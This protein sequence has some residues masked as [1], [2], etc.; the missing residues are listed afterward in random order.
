[1]WIKK[2]SASAANQS[3]K[4][5]SYN[6]KL[7]V[8]QS[9]PSHASTWSTPLP[10]VCTNYSVLHNKMINATDCPLWSDFFA[11][12]LGPAHPDPSI[13]CCSHSSFSSFPLT[14][15]V[16]TVHTI[17]SPSKPSPSP[18]VGA[19]VAKVLKRLFVAAESQHQMLFLLLWE[20][21]NPPIAHTTNL[22][23]SPSLLA[24]WI[25][26][27]TLV[28]TCTIFYCH[29]ALDCSISILKSANEGA[30]SNWLQSKH[31][32][33]HSQATHFANLVKL[34]W[35]FHLHTLLTPHDKLIV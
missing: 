11:A 30:L 22:P 34:G 2:K 19:L 5:N 6:F 20:G 1:M 10:Y 26:C 8:P 3:L 35:L 25:A 33:V 29:L 21:A 24:T 7:S 18:N 32:T 13:P 28:R 14:L 27:L 17:Y 9:A 4:S 12:H 16:S 31:I 23:G 15:S